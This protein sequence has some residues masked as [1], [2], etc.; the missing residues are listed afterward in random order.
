MT[1]GSKKHTGSNHQGREASSPYPVSR[2]SPQIELVDLARQIA[3]ADTM[4]ST[5]L[6]SQLKVIADQIRSLQK[7]AKAI[8]ESAQLDQELH[9]AACNFK[10][11]PGKIYHLYRQSSK[12]CY[13]SM[14]SP[15]DWNNRSPHAYV[16]SYR[17]END[18]SWTA[19]DKLNDIDDS[20]EL[21]NRVLLEKG[22]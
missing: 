13:F 9:H 12:S 11:L 4:V 3:D 7:D 19:I 18:M 15:E 21:V 22:F 14:L 1:Q 20:V 2:L 6:S 5:R 8:L 16:N 10:R 17:L